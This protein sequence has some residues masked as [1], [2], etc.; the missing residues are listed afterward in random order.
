MDSTAS[1]LLEVFIET[2]G[3]WY[4]IIPTIFLGLIVGGIPGFSAANTII[5][6][7]PLTLS[8]NLETGLVFMVSL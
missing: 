4:V 5:I 6:L 8:M 2:I 3:Y 1:L 7:M